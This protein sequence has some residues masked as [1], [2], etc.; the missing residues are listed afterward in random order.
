MSTGRY[1]S[2]FDF[3]PANIAMSNYDVG[4]L[5]TKL[6]LKARLP[7][8]GKLL[9]IGPG[10]GT[11]I[12]EVFEDPAYAL[13]ITT[14]DISCETSR[15]ITEH[16][17]G[18]VEAL[19]GDLLQLGLPE[20]NFDALCSSHVLEHIYDDVA[21]FRELIHVTKPG[22][23][24]ITLVPAKPSGSTTRSSWDS[25][26]HFRYWNFARVQLL[27]EAIKHEAVL[28]EVIQV[29]TVH[30]RVCPIIRL[31]EKALILP[32]FLLTGKRECQTRLFQGLNRALVRV[33]DKIDRL[34]YF[35]KQR[36]RN[37]II[38]RVVKLAPGQNAAEAMSAAMADGT[39][40]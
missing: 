27:A 39:Y 37:N 31:I 11:L 9:E 14:V 22:G 28:T 12:K 33:L 20:S 18:R 19:S 23:T 13:A 6:M 16:F 29:H 17:A 21:F 1:E 26:G 24:I 32:Y 30:V 15:F 2:Y 36:D 7:K 38:F 4:S 8:S 34:F 10:L 3:G 40:Q 5:G 35:G 25:N